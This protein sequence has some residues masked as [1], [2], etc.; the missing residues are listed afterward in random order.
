MHHSRSYKNL[1]MTALISDNSSIF[2]TLKIILD[3]FMWLTGSLNLIN[4]WRAQNYVMYEQALLG[5]RWAGL[6][7]SV[8]VM[9]L[10]NQPLILRR[11][12]LYMSHILY[13]VG[14]AYYGLAAIAFIN[15][16]NFLVWPSVFIFLTRRMSSAYLGDVHLPQQLIQ[17]ARFETCMPVINIRYKQRMLTRQHRELLFMLGHSVPRRLNKR[18]FKKLLYELGGVPILNACSL[19]LLSMARLIKLVHARG[20]LA[21]LV[22]GGYIFINGHPC[23]NSHQLLRP[24]DCIQLAITTSYLAW[25]CQAWAILHGHIGFKG[26]LARRPH[27]RG[28]PIA[29]ELFRLDDVPAFLE[30]DF[31]VLTIFYLARDL[32]LHAWPWTMLYFLNWNAGAFY[33][34]RFIY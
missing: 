33:R 24:N 16:V 34:W 5:W 4:A 3:I 14:R 15:A 8:F 32:P 1:C 26:R 19:N 11:E 9:P 13:F 6:Y 10:H 20:E 29:K 12:L 21:A 2:Q 28:L 30:L 25:L 7:R 27:A 31:N 22:L 17:A 18:I 23:T